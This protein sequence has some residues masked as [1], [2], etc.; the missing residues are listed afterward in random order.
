MPSKVMLT[1]IAAAL[2]VN[3]FKHEPNTTCFLNDKFI[4]LR[5]VTLGIVWLRDESSFP[6]SEGGRPTIIKIMLV[7]YFHCCCVSMS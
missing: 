6:Q 4:R 1:I 3:V 5:Y 2:C 7:L